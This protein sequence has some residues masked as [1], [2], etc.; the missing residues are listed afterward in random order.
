[1]TCKVFALSTIVPYPQPSKE[2]IKILC[3]MLMAYGRLLKFFFA[4]F[5]LYTKIIAIKE[6]LVFLSIQVAKV[7]SI[8]IQFI[9]CKRKSVVHF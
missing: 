7:F 8:F 5:L 6:A 1:M 9:F 2:Q 4:V 3:K